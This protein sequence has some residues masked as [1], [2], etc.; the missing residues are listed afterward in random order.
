MTIKY[1]KDLFIIQAS[2]TGES[3]PSEKMALVEKQDGRSALE[4]QYICFLGTSV[5]SGSATAV[6]VATG[7]QTY[8]G[9]MAGSSLPKCSPSQREASI[10]ACRSI[11]V[12]MPIP[13]SM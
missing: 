12:R 2:L 11:P 3:L 10:S 13:C 4:L 9:S 5:E 1:Q 8:F 7:N 6:V